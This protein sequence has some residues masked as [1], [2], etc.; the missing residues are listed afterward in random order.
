MAAS[1]S[2]DEARIVPEVLPKPTHC[3]MTKRDQDPV[4]E[5]KVS[6]LWDPSKLSAASRTAKSS[7]APDDC[8][9]S[10][11][12]AHRRKMRSGTH[13]EEAGRGSDDSVDAMHVDHVEARWRD[14][15]L[16]FVVEN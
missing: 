15:N 11:L 8:R 6:T 14:G 16:S 3:R 7:M 4:V 1:C 12:H 13:T 5:V 9:P 2:R 10:S